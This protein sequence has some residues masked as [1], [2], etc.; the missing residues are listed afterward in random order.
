MRLCGWSC[1]MV[2]TDGNRPSIDNDQC[3]RSRYT[4]EVCAVLPSGDTLVD[5]LAVKA[6]CRLVSSSATAVPSALTLVDA[7][8][9]LAVAGDPQW[10][11]QREATADFDGDGVDERAVLLAR[12]ELIDGRPAWA[13]GQPWQ[14]YIEEPDGTCTYV[15]ARCLQLG[16]LE[17]LLTGPAQRIVDKPPPLR[18][19]HG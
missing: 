4:I 15:Y 5:R 6:E 16:R 14:V 12:A 19:K 13:D 3:Q 2:Y 8:Q 10:Q 7:E 11:Y 1:W 18:R 9:P 17:A